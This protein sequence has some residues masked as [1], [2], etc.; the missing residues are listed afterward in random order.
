M[1]EHAPYGFESGDQSVRAR[2]EALV[3]NISTAAIIAYPNDN[4]HAGLKPH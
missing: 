1:S 2:T 3:I 4:N